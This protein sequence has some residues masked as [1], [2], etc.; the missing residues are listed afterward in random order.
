MEKQIKLQCS[1]VSWF[2]FIIPFNAP[3]AYYFVTFN[4]NCFNPASAIIR[5]HNRKDNIRPWSP[6]KEQR[7]IRTLR[8]KR[9]FLKLSKIMENQKKCKPKIHWLEN[10][11]LLMFRIRILGWKTFEEVRAVW[12]GD[13]E[14][15]SELH[16]RV[17]WR[18]DDERKVSPTCWGWNF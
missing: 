4:F 11:F 2:G 18:N 14:P 17:P 7:K 6:R 3:L 8:N 16:V 1:A 13:T 15:V 9:L 12:D 5:S 10:I